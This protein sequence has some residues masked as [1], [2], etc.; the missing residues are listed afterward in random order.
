MKFDDFDEEWLVV[1]SIA[2]FTVAVLLLFF[3]L[4][5]AFA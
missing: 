5:G 2:V 4:R 1:V 3:S